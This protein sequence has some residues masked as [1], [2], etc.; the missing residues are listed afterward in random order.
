MTLLVPALG[1]LPNNIFLYIIKINLVRNTN[2]VLL[3]KYKLM[4]LCLKNVHIRLLPKEKFIME[5]S[6]YIVDVCYT[7]AFSNNVFNGVDIYLT[8]LILS[9]QSG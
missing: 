6:S 1:L 8:T 3:K 5:P 4:R 9:L 2:A 7:C